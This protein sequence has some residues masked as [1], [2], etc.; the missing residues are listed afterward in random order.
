MCAFAGPSVV[1][2]RSLACVSK[3]GDSKKRLQEAV[4]C[5]LRR[6][7]S[8][9]NSARILVGVD[10]IASLQAWKSVKASHVCMNAAKTAPCLS[11]K[12]APYFEVG[13]GSHVR[14]GKAL[15]LS[16]K[17]VLHPINP[18]ILDLSTNQ[19]QNHFESRVYALPKV[20]GH[21]PLSD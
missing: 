10:S 4:G 7:Q 17:R 9:S 3:E 19:P 15:I 16:E 21:S 6:R 20:C 8:G 5:E 11:K 18:D 13:L 12:E 14:V 2:E 1:S